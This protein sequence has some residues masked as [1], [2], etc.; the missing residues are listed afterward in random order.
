MFTIGAYY[1]SVDPANVLV[2]IN[3]VQDQ[4][5][6]TQ[7]KDLRVP[8]KLSSLVGQIALTG[9]AALVQAQLASPS[10]RSVALLDIEPVV[11]ASVFGS[12]PEAMFHPSSP[13]PLEE[14]ES[15]NL[16]IQS[17]PAAAADHYGLVWLSDGEIKP[18]NGK[19]YTIRGT[20]AIQLAA[21][22]WVNGN[23]SL[24]QSLPVGKY[25]VVGMRARGTNLVAAR[26]V[27]VGYQWRPG[28]P[29][30]NLISDLDP[31]SMRYGGFGVF[32]EFDSINPPSVD[33]LG[34]TDAAQVFELDIIKVG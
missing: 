24:S 32:G 13:I 27:F 25:Q 14:D 17:D 29:A 6:V 8:R 4:H 3:A 34:I 11:A 28:V 10:L 18:V 9:A 15:L 2:Q 19:I 23:L 22:Q 33:C 1:Q 12:P 5:L 26:L 31:Y 21:G 20:A 16:S 7:G 30:V